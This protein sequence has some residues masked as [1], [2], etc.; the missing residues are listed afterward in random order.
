MKS[1]TIVLCACCT[2]VLV[3]CAP[4][5][6]IYEKTVTT[7]LPAATTTELALA[8]NRLGD[9]KDGR[10]GVK[11]ISDGEQALVSRLLLAAAAERTIDAQYYLLHN[12]PTG[13]LFAASLL[14]AADRGVRVRLLLDDIDTSGY[15]AMTAALDHHENIEI[16]LFNPFWR[17][18]GLVVAGLTDFKRINR[19]MHNKSMTADN[20]FTIVG[21]R[22]IGAEY[23]LAREE[24]NYA[25]L[26]VLAVGP[27][28]NEVSQSFDAYWNSEFAVP[29]RVV[30]GEPEDFTLSE[31]RNRLSELVEEAKQTRY[32]AALRKSARENFA[33]GALSLDWV[34]AKLYVDPPSKAAGLEN[35]GPI[36]ASQLLPY[37]ESAESEVNIVSAYFVPRNNGVRW[38]NELEN[39]GVDV[40]VVTNSLASN[41]VAPVYAH[42]AKKRRALLRSGVELYELRPDA[43]QVQRRGINW[44]QSRSG[45]HSKAFAVDDRYLFIG[46]FN[47]DPRSVNINTEMGIL[48]DSPALTIQTLGALDEALSAYTYRVTLEEAGQLKWSTRNA[49]GKVLEYSSEPTGSAWDHI[50][51]GFLGIL[52]IGSQL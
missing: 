12:D 44:A 35:S 46:S 18:Q 49:N 11:L 48:I 4:K 26:D 25:D 29:A 36:L 10:S 22:N 41:D 24:M 13:H 33:D 42:Y 47:W 30:V 2:L 17:D 7:S 23:F 43:Y 1:W 15:D 45:L 9:P 14:Q 21:G 27:V 6:R 5:V 39:R 52:P 40:K 28:V 31:A 51:A 8:A 3:A 19:R 32:G 16:R 34:P 37:F 38:L 50:V 20:V